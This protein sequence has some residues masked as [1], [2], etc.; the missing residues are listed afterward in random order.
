MNYNTDTNRSE[1][2]DIIQGA[3]I[4]EDSDN[5]I[6]LFLYIKLEP[7]D[8]KNALPLS[9]NANLKD[10]NYLVVIIK[11]MTDHL[12]QNSF[13]VIKELIR[14]KNMQNILE[15]DY[16]LLHEKINNLTYEQYE[17]Y[18]GFAKQQLLLEE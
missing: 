2:I 13:Q 4:F 11:N 7:E 15:E 17:N 5:D 16:N 9:Y 6:N 10:C 18:L 1:N 3:Y 8:L 14:K 12:G